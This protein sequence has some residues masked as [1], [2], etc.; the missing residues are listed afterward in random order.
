MVV[1]LAHDNENCGWNR[2]KNGDGQ[3]NHVRL[4][5]I[6]NQAGCSNGD[7]ISR[8]CDEANIPPRFFLEDPKNAADHGQDAAQRKVV[9]RILRV[10]G[11]AHHIET[12]EK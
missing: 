5:L 3:H 4:I 10:E 9:Q 6:H 8:Q 11:E 2:E 1:S 7:E 12:I